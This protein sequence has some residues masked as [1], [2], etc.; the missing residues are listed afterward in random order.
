MP[1]QVDHFFKTGVF[2]QV[3][4]LIA[5]VDQLAFGAVHFAEFGLADDDV[6]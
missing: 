1:Q 5:S 3:F 6:L 2:G 4:D